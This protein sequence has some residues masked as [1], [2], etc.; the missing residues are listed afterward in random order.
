MS[1]KW[2]KYYYDKTQ[3]FGKALTEE[4]AAEQGSEG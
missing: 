2:D 1:L 3:G 4:L